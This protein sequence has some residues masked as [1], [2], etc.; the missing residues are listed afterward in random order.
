MPKKFR[1][2]KRVLRAAGWSLDRVKG[3]HELWVHPDGRRVV[4]PAGGKDNREV[5]SGTLASIHRATGLD[6][7]R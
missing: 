3:S 7:L 6:D 5:P 1:D 4:I 2:V